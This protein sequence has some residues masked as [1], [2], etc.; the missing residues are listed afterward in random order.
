MNEY[1]LYLHLKSDHK[2]VKL[3]LELDFLYSKYLR[4]IILTILFH[5]ILVNMYIN[6][7]GGLLKFSLN[8]CLNWFETELA[9]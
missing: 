6:L 5:F 4:E 3:L 2:S 8:N 1:E 7:E 9:F